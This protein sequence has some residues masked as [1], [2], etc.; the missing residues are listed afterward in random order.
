MRRLQRVGELEPQVHNLRRRQRP[1]LEPLLERLAFQQLHR[2][3]RP[4]LVLVDVVDG[5]DVRV[6]QGRGGAGFALEP[7]QRMRSRAKSSGR[8]LRAT[9]RPSR[10]SSALYTTPIPPPP[11]FS[12]DAKVADR[13]ADH[14]WL[15]PVL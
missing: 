12:S 4:A 13:R 9:R 11:S 1:A 3:E 14:R 2:D 8:N 10:V 7:L 5:A 6:I 15:F